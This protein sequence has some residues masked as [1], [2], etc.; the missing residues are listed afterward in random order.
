MPAPTR[1]RS[2]PLPAARPSRA[3]PARIPAA[4]AVST[5]F[6]LLIAVAIA[7]TATVL[8]THDGAGRGGNSADPAGSAAASARPAAPLAV[9]AKAPALN[10]TDAAT[11]NRYALTSI[12][13]TVTLVSFLSTQPDT[14]DSPSRSQ[15]VALVS[16]AT[17]YGARGL[18]VAVVDDSDTPAE[19]GA[20]ANTVYDWQLG[21]VALL[22][23]PGHGAADRFGVVSTPASYLISASGTILARW[24]GYV[25][26]STAAA[27]IT[28][29]LPTSPAS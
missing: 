7:V 15:A 3:V 23:D 1:T 27:S 28:A 17:Q 29:S 4:A 24:S 13:G 16:L 10:L 22:A 6:A 25:L 9:G 19:P 14:A 8:L 2:H 11:G 21:P 20:L 26:T 18:H 12:P 5:V